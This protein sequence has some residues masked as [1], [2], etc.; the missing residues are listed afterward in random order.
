MARCIE[1]AKNALGTAPPNPMVGAVLVCEDRIIGEGFTSPFGGPH[2]EVNAIKAVKDTGLLSD[3]TLYVTLEPCS[4]FGKTPPCAD[5]IVKYKIPRV[6]IG[7]KDPHEKVAGQGI[8][9]LLAGGCEVETGILEKECRDHHR[10]FLTYHEKKRPYV[11]LKW[12]QSADGYLAPDINERGDRAEPYWISSRTS[13]QLV[14]KWRSEEQAIL[15]GANTVLMDNPSLTT[16]FWH[17]NNPIRIVLDPNLSIPSGYQIWDNDAHTLVL[18]TRI[19]DHPVNANV[20]YA[21]LAE[22]SY[23]VNNILSVLEQRGISSVIVEGGRKTFEL[24]IK[25]G[26]W[27]EARIFTGKV[28]FGSGLPAPQVDTSGA[29]VTEIGKDQ[30][31]I[32]RND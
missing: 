19:P 10:R 7:L 27:D 28:E 1:I 26:L 20:E 30:L 22:G 5:L 6:V 25:A 4:H 11:I 18:T 14:H 15:V 17:G 32:L 21:Q 31:M 16:R 29:V 9:R 3:A 23:D 12:A 13:R 24:F 2:A 8:E